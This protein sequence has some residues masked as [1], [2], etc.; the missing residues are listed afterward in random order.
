MH[1][2]TK[3]CLLILIILTVAASM[4]GCDSDLADQEPQESAV[5]EAT[6]DDASNEYQTETLVLPPQTPEITVLPEDAPY[7]QTASYD[8]ADPLPDGF[9]Y[10][11]DV[12]PDVVLEMRYYSTYNFVGTRIDG[13]LAPVSIMT[14][15]AA[16]ALLVASDIL[17]SQGYTIKIFDSFRPMDA[18]NHFVWWGKNLDDT[19]MKPFFYP[20]MDKTQLFNGYISSKSAHS[21][22]STIDLTI[23]NMYTGKEVD[24]GGPFDFFGDISNHGTGLITAEQTANRQIL[25]E[26]MEAAGFRA[27]SKEWWHYTLNNE[28]YPDTYFNFPVK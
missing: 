18:V 10:T 15:E 26:A 9:V 14:A 28:P 4:F 23:V 24:M 2:L 5:V 22:G 16:D 7:V 6:P 13:Y 11:A 12:V 20:D 25:K 17:R 1:K 21:R 27:Y 8:V 3:F 19:A